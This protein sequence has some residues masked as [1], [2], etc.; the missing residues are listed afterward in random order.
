MNAKTEQGLRQL[1]QQRGI[2]IEVL[3]K[4][5]IA[6]QLAGADSPRSGEERAEAFLA[7]ADSF[8]DSSLLSDKAISRESMYPDRR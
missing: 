4:E 5:F 2:T 7:W 6:G 1:A 3:L 8:P